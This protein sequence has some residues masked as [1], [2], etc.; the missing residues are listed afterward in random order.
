MFEILKTLVEEPAKLRKLVFFIL[1][2][3]LSAIV[4]SKLYSWIFGEFKLIKL[5]IPEFWDELYHFVFTGN[6][7]VVFFLY[8][9][10]RFL[11]FDVFSSIPSWVINYI[12]KNI[13][14]N[15]ADIKDNELIRILLKSL[16]VIKFDKETKKVGVGEYF[17]TFYNIL[18][19]Y[20]H[21]ET[22]DEVY[23][24]KNSLMNETLHIYFVFFLIYSCFLNIEKS[25]LFTTILITGLVINIL[26]YFIIYFLIQ[27]FNNNGKDIL[28][29]LNLLSTEK[30][31][32]EFL[33]DH[34]VLF[35]ENEKQKGNKLSKFIILNGKEAVIDIY[36]GKRPITKYALERYIQQAI[37]NNVK[38][39]ILI[40]DKRLTTEAKELMKKN[41]LDFDFIYFKNHLSL[42]NKLYNLI[43]D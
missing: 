29:G 10:S 15:K 41:E 38:K 3:I 9:V 34:K 26:I 25:G 21:K 30:V 14:N 17:D 16:D 27:F 13:F 18:N 20:Q 12:S 7:L 42:N 37:N 22:K 40:S 1:K 2:F 32:I 8:L 11:L 39:L 31:L 33:K 35:S 6:I 43:F 36:T 24:F 4:S 5:T 19:L 23:S 28:F